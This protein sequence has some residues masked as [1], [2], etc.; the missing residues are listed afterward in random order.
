MEPLIIAGMHRSGTSLTASVLQAAGINIGEKF[1]G[2]GLG[3][4][5][6]HYEDVDFLNFHMKLLA[7]NGLNTDGWEP[8]V[9]LTFSNEDFQEGY[10]YGNN[11]KGAW[12]FKDPRVVF[13]LDYWKAVF[14]S[15]K[16]LLIYREPWMVADSLFRRGDGPFAES[17][18]FALDI[19]TIYNE[20]LYKFYLQNKERC[21]LFHINQIVCN[22]PDF[23]RSLNKRFDLDLKVPALELFDPSFFS[24]YNNKEAL[25]YKSINYLSHKNSMKIYAL[26]NHESNYTEDTDSDTPDLLL[27]WRQKHIK[28]NDLNKLTSLH[29]LTLENLNTLEG[30]NKEKEGIIEKLHQM[31]MEKDKRISQL[32]ME[33]EEKTKEIN[34]LVIEKEEKIKEINQLAIEKEEKIKEINQLTIEKEAKINQLEKEINNLRNNRWWRIKVWFDKKILRKQ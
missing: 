3:N 10:A 29:Q 5:K 23:I 16:Y 21:I 33:K 13:F 28:L 1:L 18:I 11:K 14:P 25:T 6:G 27:L 26:L 32:D 7:K 8:R 30:K 9:P 22:Q 12:G 20:I 19:Y 17:P 2:Q 34:Q 24:E 31:E 15:G 4:E